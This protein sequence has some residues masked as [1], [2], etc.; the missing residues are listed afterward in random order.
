MTGDCGRVRSAQPGG[1]RKRTPPGARRLAYE[2]LDTEGQHLIIYLPVDD[3]T[4]AAL[5]HLNQ[6]QPGALRAVRG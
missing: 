5:D 6:R 2:T 4:S 1:V 3:A